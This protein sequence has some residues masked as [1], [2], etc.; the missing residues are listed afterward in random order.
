MYRPR[1]F[2]PPWID[3]WQNPCPWFRK[4]LE[5]FPQFSKLPP[6]LRLRIWELA[7]ESEDDRIVVIQTIPFLFPLHS[8]IPQYSDG[9]KQPH[10]PALLSV[11]YDAREAALKRYKIAFSS[12]LKTAMPIWFDF[13]TDMLEFEDDEAVSRFSDAAVELGEMSDGQ[14]VKNIA[15]RL[16]RSLW[17]LDMIEACTAFPNLE[18]I[19]FQ[20]PDKRASPALARICPS[21]YTYNH[22]FPT[23]RIP[24]EF[25]KIFPGFDSD[26]KEELKERGLDANS[27]RPPI[28]AYGTKR[29]WSNLLAAKH[30]STS[31]EAMEGLEIECEFAP[32]DYVPAPNDYAN[33]ELAARR[34]KR[35]TR[36]PSWFERNRSV[37]RCEHI[38]S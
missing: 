23:S 28:F 10:T 36:K 16:P 30:P 12:E 37:R 38:I 4:Q 6:E 34:I 22:E 32:L 25:N 17:G 8:S 1:N 27:W 31:Y 20:E 18:K 26:I 3:I 9:V 14:L 29:Q 7:V 5:T 21:S 2:S 11:C 33:L 13:G 35:Q 24:E 19:L 15:I